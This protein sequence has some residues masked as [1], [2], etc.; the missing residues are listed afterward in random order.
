MYTILL[1]KVT[2]FAFNCKM[3]AT[4]FLYSGGGLRPLQHQV[5]QYSLVAAEAGYLR[6]GF[7]IWF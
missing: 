1:C 6:Y 7:V 3:K 2:I 4:I 5:R